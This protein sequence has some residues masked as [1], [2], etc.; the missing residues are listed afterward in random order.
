MFAA[1]IL[2]NTKLCWRK[3][4]TILRNIRKILNLNNV[5]K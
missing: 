4:K 2:K 1:Y 5:R 3:L